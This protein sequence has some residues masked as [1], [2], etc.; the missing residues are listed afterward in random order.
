MNII[1]TKAF[2]KS[3]DEIVEFIA[4]DSPNRAFAFRDRIL[5]KIKT[6]TFMPFRCRKNAVLDD[7]NVRDLIYKGYVIVF[8][9]NSDNIEI[10]QI[11]KENLP[12]L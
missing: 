6:L 11:F 1:L 4:K 10:L 3:L 5:D 2:K 8:R 7:K 12:K 9:V